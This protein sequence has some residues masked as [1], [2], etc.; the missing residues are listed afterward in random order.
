MENDK[1]LAEYVT[2]GRGGGMI[3]VTYAEMGTVY[4]SHF[5]PGDYEGA[6]RYARKLLQDGRTVVLRK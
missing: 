5:E 4:T 1:K 2:S 6:L 3:D